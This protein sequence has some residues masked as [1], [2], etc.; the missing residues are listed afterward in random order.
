M[1]CCTCIKTFQSPI[2]IQIIVTDSETMNQHLVS[3]GNRSLLKSCWNFLNFSA[4]IT[5]D[6]CLFLCLCVFFVPKFYGNQCWWIGREVCTLPILAEYNTAIICLNVFTIS[7]RL[8]WWRIHST[9]LPSTPSRVTVKERGGAVCVR[10]NRWCVSK[11]AKG[12]QRIE[13]GM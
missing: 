8:S 2:Y 5:F 11:K 9:A 13:D 3:F 10:E 12:L 1:D 7:L 6:T 4:Q